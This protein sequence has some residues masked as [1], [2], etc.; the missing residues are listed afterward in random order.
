MALTTDTVFVGCT[1]PTLVWGVTYEAFLVNAT[2]TGI[3][4]LAMG[5]IFYM[6]MA[7]PTHAICYLVC[8]NEPRQFELISLWMKTKGRNMNRRAWKGSSYSPLE[9][10]RETTATKKTKGNEHV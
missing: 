10:F 9:R 4:F 1:R 3:V 7:I 6:L 5:N 2:I 8:M